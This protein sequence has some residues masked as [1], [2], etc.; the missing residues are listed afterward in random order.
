MSKNALGLIETRGLVTAAE[1]VDACLKAANVEFLSYRYTTG[2]LVCIMVTGDVGAVKAAVEAGSIAAGRIGE[3]IGMHVIPRPAGDT[4]KI[5][6]ED[7]IKINT[8][9][10]DSASQE[11][12]STEDNIEDKN[13]IDSNENETEEEIDDEPDDD[14]NSYSED[15]LLAAVVR[16]RKI[17]TDTREETALQDDKS[18]DKY[19]VRILRRI[20]R[21][22]PI[23]DIDKSQISSMRKKEILNILMDYIKKEGR[24]E[25][26]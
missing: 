22:L 15:D 13:E 1:A 11:Q 2:G 5:I 9:E 10:H 7:K 17:L 24:D 14:N 16:L 6:E 25:K 19:G 23:E 4:V 26:E 20:L 21:V 8:I 18:L 12:Q 3:V